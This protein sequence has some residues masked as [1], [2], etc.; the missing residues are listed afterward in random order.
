M[1]RLRLRCEII[2]HGGGVHI[3]REKRRQR[4]GKHKQPQRRAGAEDHRRDE[5]DRSA[6]RALERDRSARAP[7]SAFAASGPRCANVS[8][9]ATPTSAAAQI[10]PRVSTPP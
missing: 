6:V 10:K 9:A 7:T 3:G 8:T 2:A 1:P 5:Q 4:I